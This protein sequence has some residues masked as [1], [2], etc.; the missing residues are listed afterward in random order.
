MVSP[1]LIN[2]DTLVCSAKDIY[3]NP[4]GYDLGEFSEGDVVGVE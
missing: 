1:I 2:S 4:F 3:G